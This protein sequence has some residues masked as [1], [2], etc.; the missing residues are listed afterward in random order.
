MAERTKIITIEEY[1]PQWKDDFVEVKNMIKSYI[2]HLIVDVQHVGSTSVDGLAAKPIIDLD[3]VIEN[4]NTLP[5]IIKILEEND[6]EYQGMMGIPGR[7]A[8]E[9]KYHEKF[10]Y[11]FYVC[12]SDAVG[13]IEHIALRDY[14]R[15]NE[16]AKNEYAKLKKELAEIYKTDIDAYCQNKS[17]FINNILIKCGVRK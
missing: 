15:V 1:N 9:R 7:H 17:S 4:E 14:L 11:N 6:Y 12:K 16:N 3:A 13:F 2:G 8:F 5:E 10:R